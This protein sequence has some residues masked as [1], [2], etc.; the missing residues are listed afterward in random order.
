MIYL[1]ALIAAIAA[2]YVLAV[3][4]VVDLNGNII[5]AKAATRQATRA[6]IIARG[7]PTRPRRATPSGTG[8]P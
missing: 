4:P 3:E 8:A 5:V 2:T 1:T 6:D 7:S